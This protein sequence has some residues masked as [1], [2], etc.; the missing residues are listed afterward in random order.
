MH[1]AKVK[2]SKRLK[3]LLAFLRDYKPHTTRGI[4]RGAGIC[5]VSA[6]V[7]ELRM[8]G[9]EIDCRYAG[10]TIDGSRIYQYRLRKKKCA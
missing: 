7:S 5:A 10:E 3:R 9:H 4:H 8:N 6:A 1:Y 2:N